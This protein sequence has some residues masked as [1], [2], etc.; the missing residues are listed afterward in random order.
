MHPAFRAFKLWFINFCAHFG[1]TR[2]QHFPT[3]G[4]AVGNSARL[5]RCGL[6]GAAAPEPPSLQYPDLLLQQILHMH[7]LKW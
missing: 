1:Y 3:E 6:A 5:L 2:P 7:T 4:Y